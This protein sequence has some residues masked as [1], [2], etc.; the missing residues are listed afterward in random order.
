MNFYKLIDK[1]R[2]QTRIFNLDL[3]QCFVIDDLLK[4]VLLCYSEK[5]YTELQLTNELVGKLKQMGVL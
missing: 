1:D 2:N 3:V 4:I 5:D